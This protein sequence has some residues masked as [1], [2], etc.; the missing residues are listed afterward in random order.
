MSKSEK[1]V[2]PH[3]TGG[4]GGRLFQIATALA[5]GERW[6]RTVL[7]HKALIQQDTMCHVAICFHI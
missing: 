4:I 7:F 2:I 3:L 6:K 1:F 5:Y